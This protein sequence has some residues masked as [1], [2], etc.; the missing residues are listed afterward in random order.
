VLAD[1]AVSCRATG[2]LPPAAAGGCGLGARCCCCCCCCSKKA[3]VSSPA[4]PAAGMGGS[5]CVLLAGT[6]DTAAG[7]RCAV[8]CFCCAAF[9]RPCRPPC[10]PPCSNTQTAQWSGF[11]QW[12]AQD[13]LARLC[14]PAHQHKVCQQ[15]LLERV[16]SCCQL[17]LD[18]MT[19]S[20]SPCAHSQVRPGLGVVSAST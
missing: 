11:G 14:R 8:L 18:T 10:P 6:G 3:G 7:A 2:V 1:D 9:S 15:A 19:C 16:V 12:T 13:S 5:A 4:A 20:A 17:D